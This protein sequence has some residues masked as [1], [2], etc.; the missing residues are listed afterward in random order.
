MKKIDA[1]LLDTHIAIW[2]MEGSQL[3][4]FEVNTIDSLLTHGQVFVSAI[5]IWEIAMLEKMK[6][7]SLSIGIDDWTGKLLHVPG[8]QLVSLDPNILIE[9]CRLPHLEHK[10]PAD[11]MIIATAREKDL[12]IMTRD[13]RILDYASKGYIKT[14]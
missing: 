3:S 14:F 1:L 4:N 10:D 12:H 11:R 6:K 9:S 8:L 5:S 13:K 7:I 2:Y